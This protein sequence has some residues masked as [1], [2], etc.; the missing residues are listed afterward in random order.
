MFTVGFLEAY[1]FENV[2]KNP[3]NNIILHVLKLCTFVTIM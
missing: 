3:G 1:Q 2:L